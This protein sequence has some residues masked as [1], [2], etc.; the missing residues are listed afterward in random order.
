[1]HIYDSYALVILIGMYLCKIALD[2]NYYYNC[3]PFL[4]TTNICIVYM[5]LAIN[6]TRDCFVTHRK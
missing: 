1:M 5:Y 2:N 4:H 3:Y 6:L